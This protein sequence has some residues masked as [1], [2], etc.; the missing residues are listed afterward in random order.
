MTLEFISL[1]EELCKV[2]ELPI[3]H[4]PGFGKY[5]GIMPE[6]CIAHPAKFNVDLVE[7]LI[8]EYSK[9]GDILL[10]PFAGT[11]IMGVIAA[12]YGRNAYQ[13]EIEFLYF[14]W[15]EKAREN[16]ERALPV[17][18]RGWIRNIL[19]DSRRLSELIPEPVDCIITSPPY[20]DTYLGGGD[21]EK[22]RLR[23]LRANHNPK[24]FL[25]GRARNAILRHYG[26]IGRL[27]FSSSR[28]ESYLSAMKKVY[29]EFN[30][31][32][33]CGGYAIVVVKPFIRNFKV[34]DLPY[35]T[36]MLMTSCG[37]RLAKLMKHSGIGRSFWR[38][39][40]YRKNPSVPEIRHEYV[41]I[42]KKDQGV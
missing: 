19:G 39:L 32:L 16:L 1:V 25:G 10:D 33:K 35:H 7:Y 14:S 9:P 29:G 22:R 36:Y 11:G 37:F 5:S 15:M 26:S 27:P 42:M 12:L 20:G 41:L 34:V 13:V 40:Y 6:I 18:E 3:R 38:I 30:K 2:E 4:I 21:P 31:V 17:G 24:D 28:G 8:L 23:L